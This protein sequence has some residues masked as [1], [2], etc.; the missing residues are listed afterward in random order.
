MYIY[1]SLSLLG[2]LEDRNLLQQRQ[3]AGGE[4]EALGFAFCVKETFEY[5]AMQGVKND[6]PVVGAL[7][8]RFLGKCDKI[9]QD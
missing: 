1:N 3:F 9:T 8:H 6:N 5:L 2:N 4:A 7:R